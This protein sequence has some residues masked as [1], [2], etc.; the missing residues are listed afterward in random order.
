MGAMPP[1]NVPSRTF[2]TLSRVRP[3]TALSRGI[4]VVAG[5]TA[6]AAGGVAAG[7]ELERRVVASRLRKPGAA[8]E[9]QDAFFKLRGEVRHVVA[10][11]GVSLYAE[12]DPVES[13]PSPAG[14]TPNPEL[15]IVMV[16]GYA[17][18]MDCWHFQ[19]EHFRGRANIVLYDQRSHGRSGKSEPSHCRI[20]QLGNDLARILDE[21]VPE[22]PIVLMGHS[23][24]GMA[25]MNLAR[26]RPELFGT[27]IFGV[28]LLCTAAA[29]GE[30]SPIKGIPGS[31]FTRVA[32][33]MMAALNR[34]PK[35]VDRSRRAGSDLGFVATKQ[36]AFGYDVP[37]A[38][39]E[40]VSAM[41]AETSLE[42]VA[43]FYPAFSEVDETG[44][45]EVLAGVETSVLGAREDAITP[46]VHTQQIIE[47]LPGTH[48][49]TLED[50]GHMGMIGRHEKFNDVLQQLID[51]VTRNLGR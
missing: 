46:V 51:R 19:R 24:G 18:S 47:L 42:V 8:L 14:V 5:L 37:A 38:Y 7:F 6:L 17:L 30:V 44:A 43:D 40:F 4:G 22:G 39:V 33:P 45:F 32:T 25:I 41:L 2:K 28:G 48:A 16:H 31:T 11:D 21:L 3:P 1:N 9:A 26:Q 36:L 49:V 34:V 13:Y 20:P 15:T 50:C 10:D 29:L 12:I 35:L 27:R 23:M